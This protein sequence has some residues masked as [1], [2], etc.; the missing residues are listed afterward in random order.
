M[1][2]VILFVWIV[3]AAHNVEAQTF[4]EWFQQNKTQKKYLAEQIVALQAYGMVLK[5][6]YDIAQKGLGVIGDIKNGDFNLHSLYFSSL[7][8]VNPEIAKYPR[9]A[10][11]IS[12]QGDIQSIIDKS[13]SQANRSK[14]FSTA[15]LHYIASVYDRLQTDCQSTLGD[16]DA[17][18]TPGKFEMKDDERIRRINQ[19]Y[20]D[21]QSQY[22]F[23]KDF[24]GSLSVLALHKAN[25]QKDLGTIQTLYG[26]Q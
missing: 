12:I 2:K 26:K 14:A 17:V 11:I 10:D 16:L 19:L 20:A 23:A 6:G 1:K 4:A 24:S 15:E 21:S 22:R 9:A 5:K 3:F 25:E 7:K 8:A 13:K 18:T